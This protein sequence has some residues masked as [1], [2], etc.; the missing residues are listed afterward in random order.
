MGETVKGINIKLSL[1]GRDLEN[2]LKEIKSDL[3]EQEKDL[4]AINQNLKYDS[5]NLDLWKSK[6]EKLN[7]IFHLTKKRL[8]TQNLE[9]EKAKKAVKLGELSETEFNK[10][11]RNV[12][13]TEAQISKLNNELDKTKSNIK[14]LGNANFDKISKI[15]ST[16]TKSI[17][18]PVI[19]AV[20]AL[21]VL[22]KKSADTADELSDTS[23]KL[24]L[25]VEALQEWNH[26][27]TL[28]GVSNESLN[29]G[30][31]KVNSILGDIA[32]GNSSKVVE[33]LSLI[34]LSIDDL[35]GKNA[36]T[37]FETIRNALSNIKDESIRVGVAN[38]FFGDKI[39]SDLLPLLNAEKS[40]INELRKE[41]VELGI[42]TSDQAKITGS[43]NDTLDQ[44][45]QSATSLAVDISVVVLPIM[46]SLLEKL[47]D[48]II[49]TIKSWIDKWNSLDESTKGIILTLGAVITALGPF[50]MISR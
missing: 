25:S 11:K 16:L 49:P 50:L 8:D 36:D 24:G 15:G 40:A 10:M 38:Q 26:V 21:G 43:F 44:V 45:K 31:I 19:G 5:S 33:G 29:K 17:T 28:S 27:A 4:K 9:L 41:A 22:A 1:D 13:Y 32:T 18:V 35:K 2:E 7:D 48:E 14:S 39:G 12:I 47:R 34:G 6:Q 3:K 23:A 20:T 30:F 46:Q 42:I 37:A